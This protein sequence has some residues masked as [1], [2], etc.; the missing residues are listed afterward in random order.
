LKI[1]K[2]CKFHRTSKST[3]G[4][5]SAENTGISLKMTP[6]ITQGERRLPAPLQGLMNA[7][8]ATYPAYRKVSYIPQW[9]TFTLVDDRGGW[10]GRVL[11]KRT[12]P[13]TARNAPSMSDW[14]SDIL[15]PEECYDQVLAQW[16]K[17]W[18]EQRREQC[19]ATDAEE[20]A[21]TAG[22]DK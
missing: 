1:G 20:E 5:W 13:S 21:A 11:Y 22:S 3:D 2:F 4:T 12:S 19:E 8:A 10:M 7:Y 14:E 6:A 16:A 15:I 9:K 17:T 18:A